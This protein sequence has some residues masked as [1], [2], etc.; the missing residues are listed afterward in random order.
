[1]SRFELSVDRTAFSK[2]LKTATTGIRGKSPFKVRLHFGEG[3]LFVSGPGA[4]ANID[5]EGAWPGAVLIDGIAAKALASRLPD[6][7]PFVLVIEERRLKIGGFTM[8]VEAMDIAPKA[9]DIVLGAGSHAVLLAVQKH[10]AP[11]V[12]ASIGDAAI[13]KARREAYQAV[14]MA[15]SH[16]RDFGVRRQDVELCLEASIRRQVTAER[17]QD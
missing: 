17:E 11:A 12:V 3:L 8:P 5:A 7:K 13:E 2:G 15:F 4:G 14:N 10:G 16:L 6:P 1:M 9:T